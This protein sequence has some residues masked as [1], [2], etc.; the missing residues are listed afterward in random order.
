MLGPAGTSTCGSLEL[1]F[2]AGR[3]PSQAGSFFRFLEERAGSELQHMPNLYTLKA[4]IILL[5]KHPSVC[6]IQ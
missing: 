4:F 6:Y 3:A 5:I 2:G 1:H